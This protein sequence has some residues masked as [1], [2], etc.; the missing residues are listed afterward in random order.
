MNE[1]DHEFEAKL[2]SMRPAK[3][4]G[5]LFNR[6]LQHVANEPTHTSPRMLLPFRQP[7]PIG[8]TFA[9]L[10]TAMLLILM[11]WFPT[12]SGPPISASSSSVVSRDEEHPTPDRPR[13]D[14]DASVRNAERDDA[15]PNFVNYSR[16]LRESPEAFER[17]LEKHADSLLPRT[18]DV[19]SVQLMEVSS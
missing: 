4:S 17:L 15:L 19:S 16:A 10:L 7:Y 18:P 12:P 14:R 11:G 3:P 9:G 13:P 6:I 2:G 1:L 8:L 5:D